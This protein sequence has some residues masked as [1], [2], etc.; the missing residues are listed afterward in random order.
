M[1][2]S[3][4]IVVNLLPPIRRSAPSCPEQSDVADGVRQLGSPSMLQV[5]KQIELARS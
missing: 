2:P 1:S 5:G 3:S 4:V